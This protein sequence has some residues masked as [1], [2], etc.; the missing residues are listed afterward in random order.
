MKQEIFDI[1][2]PGIA[3]IKQ[4]LY[5][6]TH[7]FETA[8][9]LD[10]NGLP[11]ALGYHRYEM[12]AGFGARAILRVEEAGNAFEQLNTF[13]HK[14]QSWLLGYFSYDLKNEVEKLT[15]TNYD[16]LGF[17]ALYFFVPEILVLVNNSHVT[18]LCDNPDAVWQKILSAPAIKG[19]GRASVDFCARIDKA[20]YIDKVEKLRMHIEEGDVYELNL[21]ME[22]FAK[23]A[24]FNPLE[25]YL[26]LR[27]LSPV[28]FGAYTK[29]DN[30]L[31]ALCASPERFL[32]KQGSKLVSQPIKGTAKRGINT[33]NDEKL[34][35][36]LKNSE[37]ERAENVMIV[38]LVRND[39]GRS[40]TTGTVKVEELF[41]I[42]TFTQLH[43]MVSTIIAQLNPETNFIAAIKNAFP[44]GSMT[45]APKV[46]AMQL[47]EQYEESKRGIYS[48]SVGYISP[49]GDFDFNVV[50]RSLLY[51][52]QNGY[53]SYHVGSAITYDS[54]PEDEYD[55]CI[56][57]ALAI[58]QLFDT[59]I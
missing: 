15:S 5:A 43:Q 29:V 18:I 53:A 58:K 3:F 30:N 50:I 32:M 39:L 6:Y 54:K 27:H 52:R 31:F 1:P 41:G 11:N 8:V 21:C 51:N 20:A 47:I 2:A 40:A 37:K 42:Y 46:K 4:Q 10:N 55:E 33:A 48:G 9:C 22:F 56:L 36:E 38:D 12:V 35:N 57:K 7:G 17:P 45:G 26:N 34:K 16:G 24:V 14:H 25:S 19:E 44:M 23:N 28:P 13:Y 49:D 59:K